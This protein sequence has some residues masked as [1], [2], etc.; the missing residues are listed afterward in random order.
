[1]NDSDGVEVIEIPSVT[2]E[3]G[4]RKLTSPVAGQD[5]NMMDDPR[6]PGEPDRWT[7]HI[8]EG[9]WKD[10]VVAFPEIYLEKGVIDFT[11]EVVF[12]PTIP[13]GYT[14]DAY[15]IGDYMS[16]IVEDILEELHK[17]TGTLEYL[18][19]ETGEKID[20]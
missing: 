5:W 15:E 7:V 19:V 9:D 10:W 6:Y 11:Y 4:D 3:K 1:M 18:D 12:A 16:S 14:V 13:E 8:L 2:L 17:E 20:L